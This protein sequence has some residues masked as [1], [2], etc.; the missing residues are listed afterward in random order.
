MIPIAG[1][2]LVLMGI[3]SCA[4]CEWHGDET[5]KLVKPLWKKQP[6]SIHDINF[7]RMNQNK[8]C[9]DLDTLFN[10]CKEQPGRFHD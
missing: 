1:C 8:P 3:F 4:A 9:S 6:A 7:P 5:S 2:L 10:E